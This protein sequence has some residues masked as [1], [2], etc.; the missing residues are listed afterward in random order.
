MG[1]LQVRIDDDLKDEARKLFD[2]LG[3][4]MS[5]AVKIFFKQSVREQGLPFVPTKEPARS[6]LTQEL[7]AVIDKK[8]ENGEIKTEAVDLTNKEEVKKL[9]E[10]WE[11]EW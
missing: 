10:D 9:L 2:E 6:E 8:I 5:T 3:L 11:Y 1:K 4:D 7:K